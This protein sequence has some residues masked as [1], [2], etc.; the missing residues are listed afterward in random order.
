MKPENMDND[1]EGIRMKLYAIKM[2]TEHIQ[3]IKDSL[4]NGRLN[5]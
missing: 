5:D 3:R 2:M 1:H 4:P